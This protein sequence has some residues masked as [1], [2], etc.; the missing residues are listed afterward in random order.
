MDQAP[1][2]S[3]GPTGWRSGPST[4]SRH[5]KWSPDTPPHGFFLKPGGKVRLQAP[6]AVRRGGHKAPITIHAEDLPT[7]LEA[8]PATIKA[9]Q[10]ATTLTINKDERRWSGCV[11]PAPCN[12]I[13]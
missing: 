10:Q 11:I 3:I 8:E 6:A 5:R 12:T 9:N 4:K 7:G 13:R 2:A 1:G